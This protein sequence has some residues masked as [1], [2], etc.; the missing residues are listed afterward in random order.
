MSF[1]YVSVGY[2]EHPR[3]VRGGGAYYIH[4]CLVLGG[5]RRT[6]A[7]PCLRSR[8]K[9]CSSASGENVRGRFKLR[10]RQAPGP[11]FLGAIAVGLLLLHAAYFLWIGLDHPALDFY[12]FRQTQTALSAYW[13]W[14]D[15]FRLAYETPVLGAPWAIPYEF[16][17][18]QWLVAL[19]PHLRRA[20]RCRGPADRRSASMPARS[21]RCGFCA[22]R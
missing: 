9:G 17:L 5:G 16:P 6:F 14:H 2:R 8:G 10:A 22:R 12:A 19:L 4:S 18:Y 11:D 21:I 13:L 20:D 15:G 7:G 3:P 1:D